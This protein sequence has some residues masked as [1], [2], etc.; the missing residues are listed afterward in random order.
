M[1]TTKQLTGQIVLLLAFHLLLHGYAGAQ[2]TTPPA[3][4]SFAPLPEILVSEAGIPITTTDLWETLRRDE[5]LE[6]FRDHVYGHVPGARLSVWYDVVFCDRNALGG[7]AVQKE[8]EAKVS[9]GEDTVVFTVLVFLPKTAQGAVPLFLGLNFNGNHTIHPDRQITITDAWVPNHADLG[10]SDHRASEGSRGA[11]ASRWPVEM[12]L[13][14]GYGV[15][16]VYSGEIDPD[17][18][19]GFRNGVHRLFPPDSAGRDPGAWGTLATWAWG[20]SRALDYFETD[21]DVDAG[22]VAVI[23]HSRMGKAALWAGAE[24]ERF[25]MVVSNNSGC[26][27]AALSRRAV[28]ERVSRINEVFPHWFDDRFQEYN[29]NEAALPVDQHMLMALMA[30]RPLYVASA[31][32]DEWADPYGEYLSLYYGSPAYGLYGYETLQSDQLPGVDEPRWIGKLG[33]HIRT[34]V[35]DITRYDWE[36]YLD[37]ADQQLL[38]GNTGATGEVRSEAWIRSHLRGSAPRLILTPEI[39]AMV[40]MKLV[41]ADPLTSMGLQLLNREAGSIL[42]LEP[43]VYQK[44]GRRLL[45]VSR[46][47][48]RR[49]TT[50][51]LVYRFERDQRYLQKLEEELVAVCSFVD[52]NPSHF[53]D[54]AEMAA[55]IGLA[56]DWAGEWLSPGV[57]RMAVNSILDKALRPGMKESADNWWVDV[58]HN[59]NL[60]CHGGLAL[61]ALAVFEEEPEL[62]SGVIARAVE[63]IPLALEPY[64][65]GGIYPEGPSYWFYATTYLTVAVSALESALGS[66]F[67]FTEAPGVLESAIFSQVTAGPSGLYFNYF[68]ASLE[69]FLSLEHFGLLAW[70]AN[71][72]NSGVDLSA[73]KELLREELSDPGHSRG[74][75]FSGAFFLNMAQTDPGQDRPF[76]YPDAWSGGG[77]ESIVIFRDPGHDSEDLFLAAKGGMAADNHG[78]MDAGSFIF[79]LG[80]VR[81]SVDPGN[82]DYNTLEQ[83]MGGALWSSAQGSG[84]WTLLTKNNYGHS[85]LSLNGELHMADA[86]ATLIRED[87]RTAHPEATF[88]LTPLFGEHILLAHRT[89]QRNSAFSLRIIDRLEFSPSTESITWQMITTADAVVATDH[90]VLREEGKELYLRPVSGLPFVV[91]VVP[92]SPPPLPYDKNIPGLQRIE[93]QVER[94]AFPGNSGELMV[95]LGMYPLKSN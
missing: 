87:R 79:E 60:V 6:L 65:P 43:L 49:L 80:G 8:V 26:G 30:P 12:I 70:F 67:G 42:A 13:S 41:G 57:H 78:N 25:A 2:T 85:T 53:L 86:R 34:G 29:D 4:H 81:W 89:F 9:N 75:R 7:T 73:Y 61:A 63:K 48:I 74:T 11:N 16:T 39:E 17:F 88:D 19:D 45:G 52:W 51:A 50:L 55:G 90:V 71:R 95:E 18:D 68:D 77:E 82:Q 37:F 92:L 1:R 3:A 83:I 93:F 27:G 36:Q 56:L 69:G 38:K 33:T 64:A 32:E 66:D 35:H 76:I 54:V 91:R 15:A 44:T 40:R 84:R 23:G 46:E 72:S 20:L 10:I 28:G 31:Q 14:R 21:P 59:W 22:R 24:D 94:S 5:I 47:A 62:A 58:H